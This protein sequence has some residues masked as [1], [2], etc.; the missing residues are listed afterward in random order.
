MSATS[1]ASAAAVVICH[2][3]GGA[4]GFVRLSVA[5]SAVAGSVG[6]SSRSETGRV[7]RLATMS[8]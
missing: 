5:A 2:R 4:R 6:S 1:G 8:A 7:R 3:T